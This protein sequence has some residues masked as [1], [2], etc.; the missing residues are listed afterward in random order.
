MSIFRHKKSSTEGFTIVEVITALVV[1]GIFIAIIFRLF[2]LQTEVGSRWLQFEK[3]EQIAYNNLD[4]Y[5]RYV[6]TQTNSCTDYPTAAATNTLLNQTS[7]VAGFTTSVSQQVVSS[8][9]YGCDATKL[10]DRYPIQVMSTVTY[11][12]S[13]T[14]VTHATYVYAGG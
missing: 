7:Q 1:V 14:Q 2:I 11:G 13:S 3:A 6:A 5:S 8:M 9:P 10:S 4:K 12:P